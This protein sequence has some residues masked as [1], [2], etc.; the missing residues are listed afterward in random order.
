MTFDWKLAIVTFLVVAGCADNANDLGFW[1]DGKGG[2]SGAE[3]G[4]TGLGPNTGGSQGAGENTGGTSGS[5]FSG[6]TSGT[7]TSGGTGADSGSGGGA[8]DSGGGTAGSSEG[9]AGE[10]TGGNAGS[11]GGGG[12]GA[13]GGMGGTTAGSGMGGTTAG[14]GMGGTMAGTGGSAGACA[15]LTTL[16]ACEL[17]RDC[18]SLFSFPD[19]MSCACTAEGCCAT[20]ARCV[21]GAYANCDGTQ[22]SCTIPTPHCEG[23]YV[24]AYKG[25]CYEGCVRTKDCEITSG[26][27]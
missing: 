24:L 19:P 20:F 11:G 17:R 3:S 18:Y 21:S 16:D 14:T 10:E 22:I 26:S 25:G 9:G 6:G 13:T 4:G 12:A 8:S 27:D 5:T 15:E 1:R 2:E 7:D 23:D